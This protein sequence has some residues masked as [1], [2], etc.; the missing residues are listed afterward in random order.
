[1]R[2]WN[3]HNASGLPASSGEVV[4]D[5]GC[6]VSPMYDAI[7]LATDPLIKYNSLNLLHVT[8]LMGL[9]YARTMALPRHYRYRAACTVLVLVHTC[10]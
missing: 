9:Y 3:P 10:M 5:A 1:M 2:I 8:F 6:F 4:S 7:I